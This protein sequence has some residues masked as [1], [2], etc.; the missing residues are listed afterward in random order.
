MRTAYLAHCGQYK[1]SNSYKLGYES[2]SIYG[3]GL[4]KLN[5]VSREL[6]FPIEQ[7]ASNT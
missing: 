4:I 5:N 6:P 7:R 3:Y 1:S 2:E